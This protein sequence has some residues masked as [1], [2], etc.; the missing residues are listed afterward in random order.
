MRNMP[1]RKDAPDVV[2]P[3][4]PGDNREL[5]FALRSIERNFDYRHIWIVGSWPRWL[6]LD[7]DRLTAVKRPTLMMKYATTRAHYRWACE[8]P[9]VSDP[10]VLW[11]DDFYCLAP[12]RDLL[13]IHRGESRK[14]TPLFAT[15]TSKWAVGLRETDQLMGKLL[16]GQR[17]YNYDVHT[18]LLIHKAAMLRALDLAAGM[19]SQAPHVRTLYGN[20][21]GL[22]GTAMR[23][24]KIYT[25]NR[26]PVPH[27]W[28]SSVEGTFRNAVEPHLLRRGLGTSSPFELPGI[29]DR[30]MHT[31]APAMPDPRTARK[32]RMRYRVLKTETGTRVVPETALAPAGHP[33]PTPQERR[34]AAT[35]RHVQTARKAKTKCLSCG[36]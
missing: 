28:L 22:G 21:Q 1:H 35:A 19:R 10:W 6:R 24:P 7:H 27:A 13:P 8:S 36:R 3:C 2:I 26:G 23:D 25:A 14:V 20:L 15:W 31:P 11:N 18:P 33:D 30:N 5:R 32:A 4:R 9:D 34:M 12:V 16:P 29:P 17:L